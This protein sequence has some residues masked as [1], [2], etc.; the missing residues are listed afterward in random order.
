[1]FYLTYFW[2]KI[3]DVVKTCCLSL[4]G[5]IFILKNSSKNSFIFRK[6]EYNFINL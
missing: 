3:S 2:E 4:K 6:K 5:E 1:M